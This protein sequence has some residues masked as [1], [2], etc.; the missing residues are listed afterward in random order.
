PLELVVAERLSP[1]AVWVTVIFAPAMA[2]PVGSSTVPENWP[3]CTCANALKLRASTANTARQ[4]CNLFIYLPPG[5]CGTWSLSDARKPLLRHRLLYLIRQNHVGY[6]V[7]HH[8]LLWSAQNSAP[9]TVACQSAF[10]VSNCN[11]V[12]KR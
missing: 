7:P 8:L 1:V 4:N 12:K 9:R 3:N 10:C 11:R 5:S 6:G 2:A